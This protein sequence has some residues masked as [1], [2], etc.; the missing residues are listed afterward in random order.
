MVI[1]IYSKF[2]WFGQ[3]NS[4][5]QIRFELTFIEH[6]VLYITFISYRLFCNKQIN[7]ISHE[8]F[9]DSF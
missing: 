3:V 2:L 4:S 5:H 7:E 9:S 1:Y 8:I 6:Q